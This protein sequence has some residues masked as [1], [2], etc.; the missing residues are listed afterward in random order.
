MIIFL[1]E[2]VCEKGRPELR[3]C[4]EIGLSMQMYRC[5]ECSLQLMNKLCFIE[6]RKCF[7]SGLYYCKNCHWN[8][9]SIIPANICHNWDFS[10]RPVSRQ[11]F[12]E[13]NLFYEKPNIQLG[14]INSKLFIFVQKLGNVKQKR[15][16]LIEMKRYLDVCKFALAEKVVINATG[17]RRYLIENTDFYSIYDLVC[18]EN[19]SLNDYLKNVASIFKQHIMN[20]EVRT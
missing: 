10:Q 3:I 5:A 9:S 19:L 12:Q 17:S 11:S 8:D 14:E 1:F 18:V 13:I 4:P 16:I 2:I 6:P 20:C 7:Y 15:L